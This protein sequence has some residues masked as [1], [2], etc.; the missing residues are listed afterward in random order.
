VA[1]QFSAMREVKHA[2]PRFTKTSVLIG[3]F[4]LIKLYTVVLEYFTIYKETTILIGN[5]LSADN[6]AV[7]FTKIFFYQR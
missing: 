5:F 1:T 3:Q 7:N 4:D 6:V 2:I